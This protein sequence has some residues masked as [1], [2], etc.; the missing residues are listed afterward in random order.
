MFRR[1]FTVRARPVKATLRIVGVG[2]WD[3]WIADSH[4]ARPVASPGLHGA[5]TDYRKT[6]AY[7]T[8]DVTRLLHPGANVLSVMLG[9]G[10]FNVQKTSLE[11]ARK[12]TRY[13]K[14]TGSFGAPKLIASLELK[15]RE[16]RTE[17]ITSDSQW[18]A[19]PG[20]LLFD[21][22][23]GGEDFDA[24][25]DDPTWKLAGFDDHAWQSAKAVDGP[26]GELIPAI[27]LPVGV[28]ETYKPVKT[29]TLAPGR[30]VY[31]LGQ[32]FA[33]IVRISVH[34]PAGAILR[35]TPG[36]LLNADGTVS[37]ATFHGPMWWSYTLRGSGDEAW[38]PLFDYMGFRYVQA[39]W[40]K[41]P[42][43]YSEPVAPNADA[44]VLSIKGIAEHTDARAVGTFESS[45]EML[46]RIHHLILAAMHNNEVSL[47]TD[48]P[49]RE[50][51]G[52]L[53]QTHLQA[54]GMMFNND[55]RA[56]MAANDRNMADAQWDNG[57]VPTIA[58]EYTRFGSI[59]GSF[60]D[61]PEWGSAAIL[62]P[63][64]TY[65]FYGDRAQLEKDYPMMQRYIAA[66][67]GKAKGGI[68]EYGLGDWYDIGPKPPGL[69]QHTTLG[70][71]ATL[72]LVQ[73]A[74]TM[75]CIAT[76]L[77]HADEA[78]RYGDLATRT[79]D[80]FNKRF[81]DEVHQWYDTGSQA[82]N[83]MPLAIGI[84]PAEHHQAVLE[85]LVADIHA[86]G[87]HTNAGEIGYPYLLRAL[88]KE[89]R[90]DVILA[91]LMRKDPPS[92]GSQLEVGATALTEAWDANPHSSQD[93]LML[94]GAEQ[95][96][97]RRLAGIDFD[98]S[99]ADEAQQITV[100]P[101]ALSGVDWVRAGFDSSLGHIESDWKREGTRVAYR[102]TVPAGAHAMVVLPPQAASD[103]RARLLA[104][105][106]AIQSRFLV[107][108]GTWTFS[109]PAN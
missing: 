99:R 104:S 17:V 33:G 105:E 88:A 42:W 23:Y 103:A 13:T 29:T 54:D 45:S 41:S 95:W 101:I 21:S 15:Y 12:G 83:A 74:Q 28:H 77:G 31:D 64:W 1:T 92:Y 79:A 4:E 60:D 80:A 98:R 37:Q 34:G 6:V 65:T 38:Q 108:A 106:S 55:L 8:L 70:V 91:M 97:Y 3:A 50:K 96:L 87:D 109:A 14:F 43:P 16:G 40:V 52:W 81:W 71:T 32:N 69:E 61:S 75:E 85:H 59:Y 2:Q 39:D 26:G 58:P 86:L 84:V 22:A 73:D 44:T 46:N 20:P 107:G 24:R 56:L 11:G 67:A 68:V 63:W 47:M 62:E 25:R 78:A 102:I 72:M 19:A 90:D 35:L 94:G 82:A 9:N 76:L 10:M 53:E 27:A 36:E 66:L 48:C 57:I 5:W 100:H 93:H 89:D 18:K 49:H 7:D 30:V 51:L